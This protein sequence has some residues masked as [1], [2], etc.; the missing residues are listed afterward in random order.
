[1]KALEK[2][3]N[4]II[5]YGSIACIERYMLYYFIELCKSG[6]FKYADK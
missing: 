2:Q 4:R 3:H 5:R 6:G 1:M